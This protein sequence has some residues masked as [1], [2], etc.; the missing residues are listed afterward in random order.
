MKLVGVKDPLVQVAVVV[1]EVVP[2]SILVGLNRRPRC[3]LAK[4]IAVVVKRHSHWVA[5][6]AYVGFV[7]K[8]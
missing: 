4:A 2:D 8:S 6:V 1:E 3:R 7:V 5:G